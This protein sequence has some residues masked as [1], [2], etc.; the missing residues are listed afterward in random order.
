[1]L[2][3]VLESE[4]MDTADEARDYD[5]MDHHTVNTRF[6]SD[7]LSVHKRC[8]GGE[9]L[10][11]G[12]GPAQIPIALCQ[13][14]QRAR[15]L[16]VDLAEQMLVRAR[17][18]VEQAGFST[19]IRLERSDAKG[20]AFGDGTFEG[21]ISNTIVHHIPEPEPALGE[22]ARVVAPGGTLFVRDLYRPEDEETVALLV[23]LYTVGE[24]P[25]ARALFEA[26]LHA[27][28]TVEEVQEIVTRLG[29]P[30]EDVRMTS[31]RHWT[32]AWR[33]PG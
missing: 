30:P 33:R 20:L 2:P 19:R 3:R 16:G 31:D 32:W 26:S 15:V 7:F 24:P 17:A 28:L 22:M 1:M 21:V 12:T 29:L 25:A 6:V 5:L 9:I 11:V 13:A 8:R 10:D 23:A 27:A 14:D 18:N 4:A